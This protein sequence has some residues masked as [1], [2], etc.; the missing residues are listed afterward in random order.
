MTTTLSP[1]TP[2]LDPL[3]VKT[4]LEDFRLNPPDQA[5]WVDGE[6]IQKNGM[7][8]RHSK[9][10]ARLAFFWQQYL[11]E[12]GQGGETYVELPCLTQSQGRRPDVC[13]LAPELVAQFSNA[14]ALP[15]SPSLIA[16][17]ASPN[18]A[19]EELFAK[20]SEYLASGSEEVWLVFPESNRLLI[21]TAE[22]TLA[23]QEPDQ[24]CTQ[25][26][27]PGFQVSLS[28]LFA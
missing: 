26:V 16:E 20:A 3:T 28:E 7:T 13:Y 18:D 21:L 4:S 19:A 15:Q 22:Q 5:E 12:S 23:L 24:A 11:L 8:I 2:P 9:I 6:I 17:I 1:P 27:L 10:Q 25:K 14:S